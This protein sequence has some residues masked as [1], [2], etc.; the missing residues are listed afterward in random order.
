MPDGLDGIPREIPR[1]KLHLFWPSLTPRWMKDLAAQGRGPP[2]W[3]GAGR[4]AWYL[5]EDVVQWI[6]DERDRQTARRASPDR[7]PEPPPPPQEP[8]RRRRVSGRRTKAQQ[9]LD[10]HP[11]GDER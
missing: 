8:P 2:Y 6:K 9:Y 7:P 1:D 11:L 5:R 3:I 10:R 4:K